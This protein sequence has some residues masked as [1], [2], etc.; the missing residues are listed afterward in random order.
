MHYTLRYLNTYIDNSNY[1]LETPQVYGAPSYVTFIIIMSTCTSLD[2]FLNKVPHDVHFVTKFIPRVVSTLICACPSFKAR[3]MDL[4]WKFHVEP[5][6]HYT[7]YINNM[8]YTS[9]PG[10]FPETRLF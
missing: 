2:K 5:L 4:N 1:Q 9:S 7:N 8:R 3:V 6:V 10:K